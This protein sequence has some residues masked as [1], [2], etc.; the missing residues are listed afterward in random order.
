MKR[1]QTIFFCTLLL[2][3]GLLTAA[4][5]NQQPP[6]PTPAPSPAQPPDE[7]LKDKQKRHLNI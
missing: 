7:Q 2:A 4:P 3:A 1:M 6:A 5:Q